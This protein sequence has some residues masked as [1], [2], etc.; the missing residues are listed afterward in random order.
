MTE[1][2]SSPT[3]TGGRF[4]QNSAQQSRT[5]RFNPRPPLQ[6][7]AS[8]LSYATFPLCRV[9]ILARLYRRALRR[10]YD[11]IMRSTWGFNPRP[12]LQAGASLPAGD[13]AVDRPQVSILARLYRRAL[14]DVPGWILPAYNGFNPR[15][16]LQAGASR[17]APRHRRLGVVS[18]LARLYR[19]ALREPGTRGR[20]RRRFN[21]RPPLQAGA[22]VDL[23]DLLCGLRRFNP[24]PPLQAGASIA[25]A[26]SPQ[27]LVLFQS[28]PAFTGGRF[29]KVPARPKLSLQV[30]IL[31]RL[32]RR[33]LRPPETRQCPRRKEVSILARLYRRALPFPMP[34]TTSL[35]NP[36]Q[37]S[38][39]FTGGRFMDETWGAGGHPV[40]ILARLYRRA[41]RP[42]QLLEASSLIVSILARLYR[43]ALHHDISCRKPFGTVSILARLYRRALHGDRQ[44]SH[45]GHQFQSSPAFTGGRFPIVSSRS[46]V[47]LRV[48]IL[49]RLY[50]RALL[51]YRGAVFLLLRG[52][53]SSPAFTGGRFGNYPT[54]GVG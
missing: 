42:F 43:R 30:S 25:M 15:P 13:R 41:L 36:F 29:R 2:Q 4:P 31:A 8:V 34:F 32:Y 11:E 20:Y 45:L 3:F 46:V 16:P 1:F 27:A 38:P 48:S 49:A 7:G 51:R 24:R 10:R 52:F 50:R 33:A 22:S 14:Q 18:I 5:P 47:P 40:S 23:L 21:P 37:S 54:C 19:R 53:Q 17:Q 35:I 28:S 6:A 44:L 9:S 39:A 12:P 26:R